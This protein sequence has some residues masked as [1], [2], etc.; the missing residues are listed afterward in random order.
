MDSKI[1]P[2]DCKL[3]ERSFRVYEA[4]ILRRNGLREEKK[5]F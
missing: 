4:K 2:G 3:N 1:L 5:C